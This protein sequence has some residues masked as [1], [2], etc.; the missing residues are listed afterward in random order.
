M[1]CVFHPFSQ[2]VFVERV[3]SHGY[4]V[5]ES[6]VSPGRIPSPSRNMA[7][8]VARCYQA[9]RENRSCCPNIWAR[10]LGSQGLNV[11]SQ[12]W[13]QGKVATVFLC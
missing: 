12:T 4:W 2:L 8:A 5:L 6:D 13:F 10:S 9:P 1:C 7:V 11:V 3:V